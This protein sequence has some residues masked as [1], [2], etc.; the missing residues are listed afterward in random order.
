[1][2]TNDEIVQQ[3]LTEIKSNSYDVTSLPEA[4]S[5]D[6]IQS[7]PAM[8]GTQMVSVPISLLSQ[9]ATEAAANANTAATSATNAASKATTAAASATSAAANANTAASKFTSVLVATTGTSTSAAM[10]QK[11]TTDALTLKLDKT[12]VITNSGQTPTDDKV[13][14][15]KLADANLTSARTALTT[16]ISTLESDTLNS[17]AN[18]VETSAIV[19]ETGTGTAN[20]MSQKSVTDELAKKQDKLTIEKTTL[21][22]VNTTSVPCSKLIYDE[23]AKITSFGGLFSAH[24][25]NQSEVPSAA[26]GNYLFDKTADGSEGS[27]IAVVTNG[28]VITQKVERSTYCIVKGGRLYFGDKD[29][30]SWIDIGSII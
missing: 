14:S 2:A 10:T 5:L 16:R 13:F 12:S 19:Q 26:S 24:F 8:Q 3:V 9:P 1:M 29:A 17:L 15:A 20:V 27:Y 22:S 18:K 25:A 30:T 4:G 28:I 6:N 23:L 21:S 7:L 11:A